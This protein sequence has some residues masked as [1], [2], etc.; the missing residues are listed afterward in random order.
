MAKV[1]SKK[2]NIILRQWG[3]LTDKLLEEW[4]AEVIESRFVLVLHLI[5]WERW[6]VFRP[7]KQ[8]KPRITLKF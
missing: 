7:L 8:K 6:G 5:G 2:F 4:K 1:N 3:R